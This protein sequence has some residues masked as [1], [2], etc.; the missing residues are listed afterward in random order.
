[1]PLS[2]TYDGPDIINVGLNCAFK[3]LSITLYN[4]SNIVT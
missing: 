2:Q 4:I 1:M 3:I